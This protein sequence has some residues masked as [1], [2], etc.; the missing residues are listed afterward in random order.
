M[1][2]YILRV[3][4]WINFFYDF[5]LV[6]KDE[7]ES[8]SVYWHVWKFEI[9]SGA[10]KVKMILEALSAHRLSISTSRNLLTS[11]LSKLQ[12]YSEICPK[13]F[14]IYKNNSAYYRTRNFPFKKT[15]GSIIIKNCV[16]KCII[17][18]KIFLTKKKWDA[19]NYTRS[20]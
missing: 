13:I 19:N 16:N 10:R 2:K 14:F 9:D 5:Q 15:K 12:N 11:P 3:F 8:L 1:A 6:P 4:N 20:V 7:S 17:G 18:E